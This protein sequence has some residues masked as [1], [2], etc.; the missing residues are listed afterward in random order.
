MGLNS[1]NAP[2][3]RYQVFDSCDMN[4]RIESKRNAK[5]VNAKIY[6]YIFLFYNLLIVLFEY[7]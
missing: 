1:A 2:V 5:N 3:K 4:T 7:V 6:N